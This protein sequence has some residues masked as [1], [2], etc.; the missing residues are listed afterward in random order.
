MEVG[1]GNA[2]VVMWKVRAWGRGQIIEFGSGNEL[3]SEFEIGSMEQKAKASP[4][5][6]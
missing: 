6:D 2:E 3:K 1:I 5:V 4:A